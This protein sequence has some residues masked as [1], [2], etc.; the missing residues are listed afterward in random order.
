MPLM[1]QAHATRLRLQDAAIL[2][3]AAHGYEGTGIREIAAQ[4]QVN[5]SLVTYHFG[6]KAGLYREVVRHIFQQSLPGLQ[7]LV[8]GLPASADAS[9]AEVLQGLKDYIRVFTEA[10]MDCRQV[11]PLQMAEMALMAREMESPSPELAPLLLELTRPLRTY[12]ERCVQRLRPDLCEA[13]RFS[14]MLSIQ[15]Q[16]VL[17]R[18]ALGFIRLMRG[19]PGYPAELSPLI[20]H[21]TLFCMRGLGLP[22][23]QAEPEPWPRAAGAEPEPPAPAAEVAPD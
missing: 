17:F 18:N 22:E 1:S 23:A 3:F 21:F 16:M 15:S 11:G 7:E 13:A 5:S 10:L 6:G 19:D 14:M 4:A 20:Q 2:C 12:L 8:L 9:R